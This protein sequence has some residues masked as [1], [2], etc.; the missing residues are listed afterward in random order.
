MRS[1]RKWRYAEIE[2]DEKTKDEELKE[3]EE[4]KLKLQDKILGLVNEVDDLRHMELEYKANQDKLS[5][6]YEKGVIYAEGNLIQ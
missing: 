5:I 6:L 1:N 4:E 2:K 3:L